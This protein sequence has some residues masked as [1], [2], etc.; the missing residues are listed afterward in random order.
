MAPAKAVVADDHVAFPAGGKDTQLTKTDM[1][2]LEIW[3]GTLPI[4]DMGGLHGPHR[5]DTI[6]D[7]AN[8]CQ[9][10]GGFMVCIPAC[11]FLNYCLCKPSK[12]L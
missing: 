6:K 12:L 9:H 7:L 4:I 8:A 5:A 3:E 1:Y 2:G 11:A 10:Y